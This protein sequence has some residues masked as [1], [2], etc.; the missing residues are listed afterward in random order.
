MLNRNNQG[1]L[2]SAQHDINFVPFC[3]TDDNRMKL[4]MTRNNDIRSINEYNLIDKYKSLK[5]VLLVRM[6]FSSKN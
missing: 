1:I 5:P 6:K 2:R 4:A 3:H